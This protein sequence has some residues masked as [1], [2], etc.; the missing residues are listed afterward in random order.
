[1]SQGAF[2]PYYKWLGIPP[3]EQPPDHYRL[4]GINRL[5]S[6]LDV[7]DHAADG[8]MALLRTFQSGPNADSSQKLL[9]KVAI[10]RACLLNSSSKQDYDA[11]LASSPP[12]L[13]GPAGSTP[14]EQA[15]DLPIPVTIT[16]PP[17]RAARSTP[18]ALPQTLKIIGGGLLGIVLGYFLVRGCLGIDMLRFVAGGSPPEQPPAAA[19]SSDSRV[20]TE[21]PPIEKPRPANAEPNV[22]TTHEREESTQAARSNRPS[23]RRPSE[24]VPPSQLPSTAAN[25]PSTPSVAAKA[26]PAE[27]S[28]VPPLVLD[29]QPSVASA[30][31]TVSG[32]S[33]AEGAAAASNLF[34]ADGM[35]T[36]EAKPP[37]ANTIAGWKE[38]AATAL[39]KDF[40]VK[41]S[42]ALR[43]IAE[44]RER[45]PYLL[46]PEEIEQCR[47]A[48]LE[49]LTTRPKKARDEATEFA[50]HQNCLLALKW[51]GD[52]TCNAEL[53]E[54]LIDENPQIREAAMRA[55]SVHADNACVLKLK[56]AL[57]RRGTFA[58]DLPYDEQFMMRTG[59]QILAR[60]ATPEARD[61]L[62]DVLASAKTPAA[63]E[64]VRRAIDAIDAT[65]KK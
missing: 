35:R 15:A 5:E 29:L 19:P 49:L 57:R 1:M 55:L 36:T 25:E 20:A 41:G 24:P 16:A 18:S 42:L 23:E 54:R 33:N 44:L 27:S 6:D 53:L 28:D 51:V 22:V 43:R 63:K 65:R 17:R 64:E 46:T 52:A 37:E 31:N 38:L 62:G 14:M 48:A 34:Q 39:S 7:I 13:P 45:N 50:V 59:V 60:L 4:L 11:W 2:D 10:A 8:R 3:H 12:P 9:S 21:T 30:P 56:A 58:I 26:A 47:K 32:K 61:A 40:Q